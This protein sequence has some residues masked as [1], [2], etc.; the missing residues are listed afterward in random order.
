MFCRICGRKSGNKRECE[1][2]SYFLKHGTDEF[3]IRKMLSDDKTKAI[4]A[5]NE[6]TAEDLA[7]TYYDH[8]IET[9]NQNQVKKYSKEHFGFNTFVDGIRL[10]L[11]IIIPL[12]DEE[13]KTEVDEK[14]KSMINFRKLKDSSQ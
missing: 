11:D 14:I 1:R 9:Y 8:L 2:C 5:K 12:L 6:K 3:V 7:M 4:W 13:K 10:G